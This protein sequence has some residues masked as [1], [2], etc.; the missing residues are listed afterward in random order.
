MC[1]GAGIALACVLW[2][3]LAAPAAAQGT[4]G[5]AHASI[6]GGKP[7]SIAEFPSLAF[8]VA[9]DGKGGGFSCTGTVISPRVI[10][11]AAHCVE[12]LDAGG[13]VPAKGFTVV[14]GFANPYQTSPAERFAVVDTHVFPGFH[15]GNGHGDAGILILAVP[16][17]APP[18][19]LATAADAALYEGGSPVDLAGWGLARFD[20]SA[21]PRSLRTTSAVVQKPSSCA[22]R[23]RRYYPVYSPAVQMCTSDPP[24]LRTGGCYGDS[25]GPAIARR[26]D[27]TAVEIGIVSTGG[28]RC[29]TKLPNVFTRT[30]KV[31]AWASEWI[32]AVEQ[33][34]PPP[35]PSPTL[36]RLG[37]DE[38]VSLVG[39]ALVDGFGE[40]FLRGEVLAAGCARVNRAKARCNLAWRTG[41]TLFYG[42]VAVFYAVRRDAVVWDS[43]YR[44]RSVGY[45]CRVLGSKPRSCPVRVHRG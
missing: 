30:D 39:A 27:G 11:T 6:I 45:R 4:G 1:N 31:S 37:Q 17:A 36:P 29:S 22:T 44:I 19:A 42:Q 21:A 5:G 3:T 7:A 14:T 9:G 8:V 26:A 34:A 35:N 38:A 28:P 23:T 41:R 18:I 33:G 43:R 20:S 15:P 16:T 24:A 13:F 40:R 10:L 32:A 12:D 25:G 2:A